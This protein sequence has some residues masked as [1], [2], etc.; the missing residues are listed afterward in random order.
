MIKQN[1]CL[2]IKTFKHYTITHETEHLQL[3]FKIK[4]LIS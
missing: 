1:K 3:Y 2:K 4:Q